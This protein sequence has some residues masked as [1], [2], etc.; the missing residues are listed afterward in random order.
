ML[1]IRGQQGIP[2]VT[3]NTSKVDVEVYRIG[4]RNLATTLQ[5]GDLQRQ[6]SSYDVDTISD[7]TGTKVYQGEMDV[8]SKLNEEV[9]TAIPG[10]RGD[11]QAGARRLRRG[12]QAVARNRRTTAT[13]APRSGSSSPTSASPPSTAMTACTR[14][15]RSLSE[16]TAGCRA[17]V[18]LVARNNEVLARQRPT[19]AATPSSMPASPRAKAA[20]HRP[21]SSPR[22]RDGEYAFL[23]LTLNAFDLPTAASRAAILPAP[24]TPS[25]IPSAASIAPARR[26]NITAL[27]RDQS[28]KASAVPMTLIVSRPDG[29]EQRASC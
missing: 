4:D 23:D 12:R 15:V 20:R 26:C 1:P 29:V 11:R 3:I 8:A 9:T 6:L 25:S 17:T 18:K 2:L 19:P 21:C 5:R 16:A 7:R 13:S 10:H 14:F 22:R 28:G 27:V 24:S